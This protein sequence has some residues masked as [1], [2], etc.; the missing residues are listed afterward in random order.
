MTVRDFPVG[1]PNGREIT[2][3]LQETIDRAATSGGGRVV[4]PIGTWQTGMIE[5]ADRIELHL[6]RGTVLKA[7][8]DDAAYPSDRVSVLAE[9]SDRALIVAK[10]ASHIAITGPGV[11][12]GSGQAWCEGRLARGVKLV[13]PLRPRVIVF[14]RCSDVRISDLNIRDAPMWTVHLI[15][16]RRIAVRDC[17]IE[18]DLSLPNTDGVNFDGCQDGEVRDCTITAADD[19]V[20]LKTSEHIDRSGGLACERILVENCT[21]RS[22]SCAVKLGSE[23]YRDIRDA[24]IRNC[25][26]VQSNRAFGIFS[27]DGGDIERVL[28]ENCTV[29]CRWT[30]D[31]FWGNGEALTINAL[32]RRMGKPAGKV[33]DI[34]VRSISGLMESTI[35]LVGTKDLPLERIQLRD[36][37]LRQRPSK[38][39]DLPELDLRPTEADLNDDND[40]TV[41]I[42]NA[43]KLDADGHVIGLSAYLDG[44]PCLWA[45]WVTGLVLQDVKFTRPDPLPEGWNPNPIMMGDGATIVAADQDTPAALTATHPTA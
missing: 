1:E 38:L 30:P 21:F 33:Q 28:I 45:E 8:T 6:P 3:A 42:A 2:R 16:C 19:C 31:G 22:N 5:L 26:I 29:D 11:I 24:V 20:C 9:N 37:T 14:E 41:G 12:D 32:P 36:I 15:D 17:V 23:T 43:W 18:N 25:R 35:N 10:R 13:R 44:L 7:A 40:P 27:R 34:A 4:L 39:G